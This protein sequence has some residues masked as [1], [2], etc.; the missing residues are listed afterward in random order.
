MY[1]VSTAEHPEIS[2]GEC[3]TAKLIAQP[4]IY[5]G[6]ISDMVPKQRRFTVYTCKL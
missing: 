6:G 1:P 3:E 5:Q 2:E 4:K